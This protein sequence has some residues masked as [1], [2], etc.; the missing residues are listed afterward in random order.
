MDFINKLASHTPV[1]A[2]GAAVAN[3]F[4]L[5]VALI[6]KVILFETERLYPRPEM[7]ESLMTVRKEVERLLSDAQRLVDQDSE[8]YL[9]YCRSRRDGD[10]QL[11]DEH[12]NAIIDVSMN[13]MEKS[14]AAFEWLFQLRRI[15]PPQMITHLLV[16]GEILMGSVNGT[17]HVVNENLKAIK[18]LDKRTTYLQRVG[19]LYQ[20]HQRRYSEVMATLKSENNLSV[21]N[22]TQ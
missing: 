21:S 10:V 19:E 5:S 8:A 4:C 9:N 12:F 11:M 14:E 20:R 22:T 3:S 6:Y 1:P 7:T 2:G 15:V 17:V 18:S 16:A 13:L